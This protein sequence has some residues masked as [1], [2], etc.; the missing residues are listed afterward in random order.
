MKQNI[1]IPAFI[2]IVLVGGLIIVGLNNSKSLNNDL[3][4][5]GN[6]VDIASEESFSGKFSGSMKDLVSKNQSMK[7]TFTHN[8]EMNNS[9]GTVYIGDGK[10]K[11]DFD[12]HAS[13]QNMKAFMIS[14]GSTSYVWSSVL[15]QGFKVVLSNTENQNST[16]PAQGVDY[17]QNLDYECVPWSVDS[18]YFVPPADINFVSPGMSQIST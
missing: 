4:S 5:G 9:K 10:L 13:G 15:P 8:T 17:N 18:S 2:G 6:S 1:I 16:Q 12:I 14:D 11:G 7:C 3:K